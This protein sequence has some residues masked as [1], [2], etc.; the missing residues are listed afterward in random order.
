M[1][2]AQ[3]DH[4][5]KSVTS[6]QPIHRDNLGEEDASNGTMRGITPATLQL[7]PQLQRERNLE[8]QQAPKPELKITAP[9]MGIGGNRGGGTA[10]NM[11][12]RHPKPPATGKTGEE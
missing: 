12:N 7:A 3:A 2:I 6:G 10:L 1:T 4:W 9:S 8:L 11:Q 5:L